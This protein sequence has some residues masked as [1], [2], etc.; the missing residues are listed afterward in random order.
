MWSWATKDSRPILPTP[1]P[2]RKKST[3]APTT[4]PAPILLPVVEEDRSS[5]V[6]P[7][8]SSW[9]AVVEAALDSTGPQAMEVL[10][11]QPAHLEDSNLNQ[12]PLKTQI[13]RRTR[14]APVQGFPQMD[15]VELL[16]ELVRLLLH[17]L[18]SQEEPGT[19]PRRI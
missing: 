2:T 6:R 15:K 14:Q 4:V 12:I 19:A 11:W 7:T 3:L 1:H 10:Q 5:T 17:R 18:P 13:P 8:K 9:L 16:V